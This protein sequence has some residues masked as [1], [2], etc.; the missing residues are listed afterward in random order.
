MVYHPALLDVVVD[1]SS[2]SAV[3]G[4]LAYKI[5]QWLVQFRKI[6]LFCQPVIHLGIGIYG[7]ITSPWWLHMIVPDALQI[8]G[9]RSWP[10]ACNH[11]VTSKLVVQHLQALV[12][13]QLSLTGKPYIGR[14]F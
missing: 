5:E 4:H 11:Q 10:G 7:V 6:G 9:K 2:F 3:D 13:A 12:V 8:G 14:Q 1:F